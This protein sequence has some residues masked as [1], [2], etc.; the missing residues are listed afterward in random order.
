[1]N[2]AIHGVVHAYPHCLG[3]ERDHSTQNKWL[4]TKEKGGKRVKFKGSNLVS[5]TSERVKSGQVISAVTQEMA[6][7]LP[8]KKLVLPDPLAPTAKKIKNEQIDTIDVAKKYNH[9]ALI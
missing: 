9:G 5:A 6:I 3:S 7:F 1:M 4:E 8:W 2:C